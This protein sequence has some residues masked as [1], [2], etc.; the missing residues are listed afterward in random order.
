MGAQPP[1][2]PQPR[3]L[4]VSALQPRVYF[5]LFP[6][7]YCTKSA[8]GWRTPRCLLYD[9]FLPSRNLLPSNG[10]RPAPQ[11]TG[12][13]AGA[14]CPAALSRHGGRVPPALGHRS[15]AQPQFLVQSRPRAL[16]SLHL[17][18]LLAPQGTNS[19]QYITPPWGPEPLL[20]A[21]AARCFGFR[22]RRM[23]EWEP[24]R[25]ALKREPPAEKKRQNQR[26]AEGSHPQ[27]PARSRRPSAAA[28]GAESGPPA[29]CPQ[30]APRGHRQGGQK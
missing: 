5:W 18:L 25:R 2:P 8:C 15:L 28:R 24:P 19:P 20:A 11:P 1:S 21:R 10:I 4:S 26:A 23:G 29:L 3:F 17:R 22:R 16:P 9:C 6:S 13:G 14:A 30:V 7:I 27:R 12:A